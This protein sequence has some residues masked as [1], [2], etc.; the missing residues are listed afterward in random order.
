MIF[1]NW[2]VIGVARSHDKLKSL[3]QEIVK[4][5][6]YSYPCD[7]SNHN[8]V[9]KVS[10]DLLAKGLIPSLFFLNAGVAGEAACESWQNFDVSKH[11]EIFA[12]NYFGV[13][14]WVE[15]WLPVCQKAD[16]TTFVVTSSVNAIFAPPCAS[17][18]A[19]SKAAVA[20]AF[21]GLSL[22][23]HNSSLHFLVVY[24]GPVKTNGLKGKFP[25]TWEAERMAKRM[26]EKTLK[27]QKNI[28]PQFFYRILVRLLRWLP[29]GLVLKI[30][31]ERKDEF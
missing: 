26:I 29:N 24:P 12:T 21:E 15:E 13:L 19:A 3:S 8:E 17:A 1:Q 25:F 11:E 27:K 20:K 28:E 22:T 2:V 18:Y 7:V 23:Y 5:K 31:G 30:F 16:D 9:R 4:D 10:K 6:F 14:H